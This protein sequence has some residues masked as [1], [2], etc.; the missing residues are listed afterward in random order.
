MACARLEDT[1]QVLA[2]IETTAEDTLEKATS[3]SHAMREHSQASHDVAENV[4]RIASHAQENSALIGEASRIA[5]TMNGTAQELNA[6][7]GRFVLP[8]NG[9]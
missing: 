6:L 4:A 7:V 5:Q 3:I 2:H 1:Q 9:A 8:R